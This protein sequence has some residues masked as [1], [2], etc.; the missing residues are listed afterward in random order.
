VL[1]R[2]ELLLINY[3][4]EVFFQCGEHRDVVRHFIFFEIFFENFILRTCSR[5][6]ERPNAHKFK[7][8]LVFGR[9]NK[10]MHFVVEDVHKFAI[11]H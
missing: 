11:T 4:P 7:A 9:A 8:F 6:V 5:V 2:V 1:D 3:F 10:C